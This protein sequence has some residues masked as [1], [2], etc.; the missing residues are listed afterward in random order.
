VALSL[1]LLAGASLLV[2]SF[3]RLRATETG[4]ALDGLVAAEVHLAGAAYQ[5]P[6]KQIAF[7]TALEER[8]RARG[9]IAQVGAISWLP[10][11]GLGAGTGYRALD[12]PPPPPD[13]EPVTDV[14]VVTPGFFAVAGIE[15]RAGRLINPNDTATS[16]PVVVINETAARELWPGVELPAVLG[17]RVAMAWGEDREAEVVGVVE[18]ARLESLEQTP[19]GA[20]YWALPQLPNSFLTLLVRGTGGERATAA[21]GRAIRESVTELDPAIPVAKV[22]L[23]AD[24]LDRSVARPRFTSALFALFASIALLVTA[25]GLYGVLA[26]AVV[27]RRRELGVRLALGAHAGRLVV[28]V[29]ARA[30]G[31]VGAGLALGVPLVWVAARSVRALLFGVPASDPWSLALA[32]LVL[33]AVAAVASAIPAWRAA[34]TDPASVLRES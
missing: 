16:P 27:E 12:Q 24:V 23:L 14:R 32:P 2:K 34:R 20:L 1:A 5:E 3:E 30:L 8:L 9:E 6:A 28:G 18:S 17:R 29:A 31:L 11:D 4:W 10:F 19:R 26:G 7:F 15:L 13:Q 22:Q 33:L 21:A 25:L